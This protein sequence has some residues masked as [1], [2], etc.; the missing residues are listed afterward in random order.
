MKKSKLATFDAMNDALSNNRVFIITHPKKQ[1]RAQIVIKFPR[2]GAG[3]LQA[4]CADWFGSEG[5]NGVQYGYAGGYGYD[6][7]T[8]AISG[9]VIDGKTLTDHACQDK[10]S[11]KLLKQYAASETDAEKDKIVNKA[12]KQGYGFTNWSDVGGY[13]PTGKKGYQ[14]CYKE[15]G[16]DY[17][18]QL[19]YSIITIG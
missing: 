13:C 7:V 2:D 3:K 12:R 9:F 5:C 4:W 8:A 6:K 14:S 15:P 11:E 19:G 10:T 18:R 1:G 17:L 16:T